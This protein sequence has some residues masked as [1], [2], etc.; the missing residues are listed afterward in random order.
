MWYVNLKQNL[1]VALKFYFF[2]DIL[3]RSWREVYH[4]FQNRRNSTSAFQRQQVLREYLF[5]FMSSFTIS[6]QWHRKYWVFF[7]ASFIDVLSTVSHS[8][9]VRAANFLVC[10]CIVVFPLVVGGLWRQ[11]KNGRVTLLHGIN[12][13]PL[14][15]RISAACKHFQN[16]YRQITAESHSLPT[17][18]TYGGEDKEDKSTKSTLLGLSELFSIG[19]Q[20]SCCQNNVDASPKSSGLNHRE[21]HANTVSNQT[22][23]ESFLMLW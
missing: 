1:S 15:D 9:A 17:S 19:N 14:E 13:V 18:N 12:D 8:S 6:L 3:P 7:P 20:L 2:S 16:V 11:E 10:M 4:L 21:T 5:T 22:A 23:P